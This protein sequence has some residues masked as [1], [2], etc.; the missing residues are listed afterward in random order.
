MLV[1]REPKPMYS[2]WYSFSLVQYTK[3]YTYTINSKSIQPLCFIIPLN[4]PWTISLLVF[5][6]EWLGIVVGLFNLMANHVQESLNWPY[7]MVLHPGRIFSTNLL[8]PLTSKNLSSTRTRFSN[9][10]FVV[11]FYCCYIFTPLPRQ[12]IQL[13]S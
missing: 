10:F 13:S 3:P 4:Y 6:F 2:I 1:W 5:N 12:D 9:I 7:L 8:F 11:I